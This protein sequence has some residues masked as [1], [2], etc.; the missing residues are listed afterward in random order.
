MFKKVL[1]IFLFLLFSLSVSAQQDIRLKE[2]EKKLQEVA[3]VQPGLNNIVNISINDYTL[4][5]IVRA[6]AKENKLNVSVDPSINATPSYNFSNATVID[7]FLFLCKE[8]DLEIDWTGSIMAFKKRAVVPEKAAPIITK[9]INLQYSSKDSLFAGDLYKDTLYNVVKKMS[10]L[11][12]VNV[13]LDPSLHDKLITLTIVDQKLEELIPRLSVGYEW[14]KVSPNYYFISA[15]KKEEKKEGTANNTGTTRGR[16]G[17]TTSAR[18]NNKSEGE[19]LNIIW[20]DSLMSF[21]ALEQPIKDIIE[22]ISEVAG[23]N[24][25]LFSEPKET[26]TLNI[27]N[28]SYESVLAFVLNTSDFTFTKDAGIYIIGERKDERLRQTKVVQLQYRTT[29]NVLNV[30]PADLK[31]NVEVKEFA[32]LNSLILSGSHLQII[33]I[34]NFLKEIDKSVPVVLIEV[35][36]VEVSKTKSISTGLKIGNNGTGASSTG[37]FNTGTTPDGV[38]ATLNPNTIN[39]IIQVINGLGWF[40]LG[41]VGSNF[42]INL[43]AL[44]ENGTLKLHSTPKLATLNGH[45]AKMSIG[46][47]KY[48]AQ[49]QTNIIGQQL[50]Q[51][52]VTRTFVPVNADLSLSI[53]PIVSGDDQITLDITV[54]QSTFGTQVGLAPPEFSKREFQSVIRMKNQEMVIL[55]GLENNK[56]SESGSGVPFLSRI[57]VIKWFFSNRKKSDEKTQLT[58][59]IRPTV[60]Y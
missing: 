39:G 33:E 5:E 54:S 24:Y 26:I 49:D 23:V 15:E 18:S 7:V 6:I 11:S 22:Q 44:E 50:P 59:F 28:Q 51:T 27:V 30:I 60:I 37:T 48:Y 43:N 41:N 10:L 40:N 29:D 20:K 2:I 57:P 35:M 32:E 31:K 14:K 8:H 45:E 34:Q 25:Y 47:T 38:N 53:K 46:E 19:A 13:G 21:S 42:Y 58:L 17:G 9:A 12:K 36:I 56:S 52:V 16:S 55:G 4:Q 3:K 1:H